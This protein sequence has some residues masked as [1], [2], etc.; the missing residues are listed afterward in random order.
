MCLQASKGSFD[1]VESSFENSSSLSKLNPH[2]TGRGAHVEK[3]G[4]GIQKKNLIKSL[5]VC[6][7]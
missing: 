7:E 6:K 4:R 3:D 2:S 1:L 5:L